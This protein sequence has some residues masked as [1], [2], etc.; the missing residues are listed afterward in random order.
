MAGEAKKPGKKP[1]PKAKEEVKPK[2]AK[3]KP[4]AKRGKPA[5]KTKKP[6]ARHGTRARYVNYECRC[7]KCKKANRDYVATRRSKIETKAKKAPKGKHLTA[8]ERSIRDSLI[9]TRKAQ[10]W[11]W[12]AIA[13]EVGIGVEATK[14][15]HAEKKATMGHFMETDAAKII[16]RL[17]EGL[18]FSIGDL[19]QL[20]VASL[21]ERNMSAA[22]SAKRAA[23]EAR[24]KL[25]NL[26]QTTGILPNDL[27]VI[28]HQLEFRVIVVEIV[29]LVHTFVGN[30][31]P[32]LPALPEDKRAT[33][34]QATAAL[35]TG[36]ERLDGTPVPTNGGSDGRPQ[37]QEQ[38]GAAQGGG[39]D[40]SD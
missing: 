32:L 33:F 9:V 24:E 34:Q 12:A 14:K 15:A 5:G 13:K 1:A 10:N 8:A 30:V 18:E 28:K 31:E 7:P 35:T 19:E 29:E 26:M 2:A 23:N 39:G 4:K 20:A 40:S 36:L 21:E 37:G 11:P 16:E 22:V 6:E 25:Q 38:V 3:A 17:M 27:G